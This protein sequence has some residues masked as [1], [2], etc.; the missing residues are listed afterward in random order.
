MLQHQVSV[1][2]KQVDGY[3]PGD[4]LKGDLYIEITFLFHRD[5]EKTLFEDMRI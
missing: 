1:G 4:F 5:F 3:C 2:K